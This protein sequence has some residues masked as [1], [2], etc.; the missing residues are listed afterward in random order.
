MRRLE[1]LRTA[2]TQ[3]WKVAEAVA[4]VS[5]ECH[6]SKAQ[7]K[8]LVR[9]VSLTGANDTDSDYPLLYYDGMRVGTLD[10]LGEEIGKRDYPLSLVDLINEKVGGGK[11]GECPAP[12]QRK[13]HGGV[14][15]NAMTTTRETS[16]TD[17]PRW[18]FLEN[19]T[20]VDFTRQ[21]CSLLNSAFATGKRRVTVDISGREP[22]VV[23]FSRM[24]QR[25]VNGD[26]TWLVRYVGR[27]TFT[28][29]LLVQVPLR[30]MYQQVAGR[31]KYC[32]EKSP[33]CQISTQ[34]GQCCLLKL[35]DE[36][37]LTIFRYLETW[38]RCQCHIGQLAGDLTV[39]TL[40]TLEMV[41]KRFSPTR[42]P[43][44][45]AEAFSL[46]DAAARMCC[47]EN[48]GLPKEL[49]A[50]FRSWKELLWYQDPKVRERQ[51]PLCTELYS[52]AFKLDE[53]HT[54]T[55][56]E[57]AKQEIL[58]R[59]KDFDISLVSQMQRAPRACFLGDG[60][61]LLADNSFKLVQDIVVGDA[62]VTESGNHRKVVRIDTSP[63]GGEMDIVF[64]NGLGLTTGHP[65]LFNGEWV[66]PFEMA[67][68]EKAYV[69]WLYNFELD[70]GPLAADHSMI[71]NGL[72]VATLGKDCGPRLTQGWP[73]QDMLFGRGYWQLAPTN[74][75]DMQ[76]R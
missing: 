44:Q 50:W 29:P 32:C 7:T 20:W 24:D 53:K 33:F 15:R 68:P 38:C 58:S 56:K 62:V 31:R 26:K 60:L 28:R 14:S 65:L 48:F 18:Q 61:V 16:T 43:R 35:A 71:I 73:K 59:F 51:L 4:V 52:V 64:I 5:A 34:Y 39:Q 57:R 46:P 63:V 11:H 9:T 30:C 72:T 76:I 49:P 41:C 8:Q 27:D 55:E 70:G 2:G 3:Q 23:D 22:A 54:E 6:F 74:L 21:G 45:P 25:L 75:R 17:A 36:L 42:S 47:L 1:I 10:E 40:C 13:R 37:L 69:A 12:L 66:H 19:H 67:S